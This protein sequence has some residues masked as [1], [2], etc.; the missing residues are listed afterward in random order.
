L[1][2]APCLGRA[3]NL[4]NRD[5]ARIF[6]AAAKARV[7]VCVKIAPDGSITIAT[8]M[9]GELNGDTANPWDEVLNGT[10]EQKRTA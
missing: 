9:P 6:K 3:L 5:L 10:A 8:G 4:P 2:A 7:E 1:V